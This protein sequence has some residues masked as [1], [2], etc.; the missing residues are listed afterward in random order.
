MSVRLAWLRTPDPSQER[1]LLATPSHRVFPS[2]ANPY[3]PAY[4]RGVRRLPRRLP[5]MVGL[6]DKDE[7]VS[8]AATA[9]VIWQQT[10]GALAWL[11]QVQQAL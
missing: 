8:Y 6:G 4:L 9:K 10:P 1:S 11:A 3:V 2:H 7:A 5:E